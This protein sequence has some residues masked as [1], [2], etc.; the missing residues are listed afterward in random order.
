M[1]QRDVVVPG[2]RPSLHGTLVVVATVAVAMAMEMA[3]AASATREA[4]LPRR[5]GAMT[6][7]DDDEVRVYAADN[8]GTDATAE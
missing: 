2:L 3:A 4:A 6:V 7:C 1:M 5:G 8:A